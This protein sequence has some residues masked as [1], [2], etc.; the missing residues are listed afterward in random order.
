MSKYTKEEL[1]V[2]A[3]ISLEAKYNFDIRWPE[4]L[5]TISFITNLRPDE[6]ESR[7]KQLAGTGECNENH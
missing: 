2:M 3:K 4:L 7:I 6:I 1:K 5:T